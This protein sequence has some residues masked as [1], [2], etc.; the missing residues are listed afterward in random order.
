MKR[1]HIPAKTFLLGE[2]SALADLG[3]IILTTTPCF[4]LA[5]SKISGLDGIHP[6]SPAGL[7]WT[8]AKINDHGL[9]WHDPYDN[10]GGMGASTAQFLGAYWA[11]CYLKNKTP[12]QVEMLELYWQC[13]WPGQ[14]LKPSGYD[15]I[16][17]SSSGCVS[18]SRS[19]QHYESFLWN[20]TDLDFILVHTG[21]KL[22]THHHLLQTTLTQDVLT[23]DAIV[24][25]AK[26]AF[27]QTDSQ[28]LVNAVN[29]YHL[30][31]T[32]LNLVASNTLNLLA[33]FNN[34]PGILA[35][36][37]CGAMGADVILLMVSPQHAHVILDT[38]KEMQLTILATNTNVY[39]APN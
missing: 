2:Y 6:E 3:A 35:A 32:K 18:I 34:H 20:F 15:L 28:A 9:I 23:L 33:L 12:S 11:M 36:K 39:R 30:A 17:Q 4:E 29:A 27:I 26:Q 13:A 16:A 7:L 5:L 24:T 38:L 19:N 21:Q 25:L 31:L 22:P 14:G 10:R 37:G 8:K 1:W